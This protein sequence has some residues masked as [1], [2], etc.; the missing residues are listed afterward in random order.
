MADN[1]RSVKWVEDEILKSCM[2]KYVKQ[3]L[4]RSEIL[5][6]MMRDFPQYEWSLRSLDR[7][8]R[9]FDVYYNDDNVSV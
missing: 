2:E 5:D 8:L 9:F 4:Q 7:R 3:S 1:N 6:F